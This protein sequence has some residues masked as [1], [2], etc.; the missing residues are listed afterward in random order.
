M[1][2]RK[3]HRLLSE[4]EERDL[5]ELSDDLDKGMIHLSVPAKKL[6]VRD[7]VHH[8]MDEHHGTHT[9]FS[10]RFT[11]EEYAKAQ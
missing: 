5:D 4:A 11:V 3:I 7:L 1:L 8:I 6:K 10:G 9:K 2:S